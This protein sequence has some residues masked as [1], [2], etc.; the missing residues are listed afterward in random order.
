MRVT[1]HAPKLAQRLAEKRLRLG[2]CQIVRDFAVRDGERY[3]LRVPINRSGNKSID[4]NAIDLKAFF[5]HRQGDA[6]KLDNTTELTETWQTAPVD[7][8]TSDMEI[9]D[10]IYTLPA[11]TA[12]ETKREVGSG[13]GVMGCDETHWQT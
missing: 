7:W 5:Y 4:P 8:N 6:V 2:A 13:L 12:A 9:V 11:P 10:V 1:Q 3:V